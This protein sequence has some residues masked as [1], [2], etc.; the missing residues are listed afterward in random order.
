M[1]FYGYGGDQSGFMTYMWNT[2][3]NY[4]VSESCGNGIC[5]ATAGENCST[6]SLDC[7]ICAV[8]D[9][10]A[11][12]RSNGRPT[13]I[14]PIGTTSVNINLT[15]DETAICRYS[16]SAGQSYGSMADTFLRN[17]NLHY[18]ALNGLI[19]GA[20]NYY[21][22]CNDSYGNFNTNDYLISFSIAADTIAPVI[23][24]VVNS[25]I[26][27]W[28]AVITWQ[29]NENANSRIYYGLT[30]SLGLNVFDA[31]YL[32]SH[33][34]NL[35]NLGGNSTYYYKVGSCDNV[36]NCA[37]SSIYN[38]KTLANNVP[39]LDNEAPIVMLNSPA[40]DFVSSAKEVE[41]NY[42]VT[43]YSP[44]PNC[45]VLIG[46]EKR[47]DFNIINGK[48]NVFVLSLANGEYYWNISC[49]DSLGN[50]GGS[51]TRKFSVNYVAPVEETG[52]IGTSSGGG[53]GGGG[54]PPIKPKP[55]AGNITNV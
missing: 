28:S 23:S 20:H 52:D 30:A 37:N 10:T 16:T 53:G 4:S 43:D 42:S 26:T 32:L 8:N 34:V 48:E 22:R 5:N 24:S 12:V 54:F 44:I 40:N 51:E 35:N 17:G 29:T 39:Y 2:Y 18:S 7:G 49:V 15:T 27:N 21:A 31:G 47:I 55:T 13:G 9:T 33:I 38:F 45:S 1:D 6:C 25:S 36:V 3:R 41:F 50:I 11:P 14:L 19:A 46:V